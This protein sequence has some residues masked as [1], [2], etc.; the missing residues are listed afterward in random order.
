[1]KRSVL[2]AI[3]ILLVALSCLA[4]ISGEHPVSAPAYAPPPGYRYGAASASNG[5]DFLVVWR[6]SNRGSIYAPTRIYAA[7]ISASGQLLDPAGIRIP[8]R[9]TYP[10]QFN[11]VYL[12]NS[13]LVCWNEGDSSVATAPPPLLG[14]RV[15]TEGQLLDSTPRVF[16]DHGRLNAGGVAS[17][18]SRAVIAYTTASGSLT[19]IVLD[20]DANVVDGPR[21]LTNPAVPSAL[22]ALASSNGRGFLVLQ[23]IINTSYSAVISLDA[24]GTIT[25]N[26]QFL[27]PPGPLFDLASD[28]DGYLAIY[29]IPGQITAKHFGPGGDIL[30]T[31]TIPLQQTF[32]GL[33]FAG[34]SYLLVDA[35]SFQNVQKTIGIRRLSRTGQPVGGYTPIASVSGIYLK[36]TT[37]AFN[38]S[39]VFA[40]WVEAGT[41]NLIFNGSMIEAPTLA[42]S[43]PFTVARAATTQSSPDAASSGT[44]TAVVWNEDD[45]VYAARLT[46]DGQM[47]DGRGIRVSASSLTEAHIAFDGANYV[48]VW[49]DWADHYSLKV[50]RLAPGSGALLDPNGITIG[51][52]LGGYPSLA[53]GPDGTLLTCSQGRSIVATLLGRDLSHGPVVVV[54]PAETTG[55]AENS[56][57]WNG[58]EWLLTWAKLVMP[59]GG[60]QCDPVPC[61]QYQMNAA[62]LSPQLA[63]LDSAPIVI[64]DTIDDIG[65]PLVASDGDGFLV[66]WAR[67]NYAFYTVEGAYS[68]SVYTR[69]I[70]RDGALLP[71]ANV[72]L[73]AGQ[74]RSIAWDGLQY[75]VASTARREP[76]FFA[77][78]FGSFTA[79]LDVTHVAAHG[80]I[81]SLTP[82]V[83]LSDLS[84][85]EAAL[86]VTGTGRVAIAYTRTASEPEYG[87]VERVFVS[88]PH[89]IRGRAAR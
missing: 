75:D 52:N 2:A 48:I 13:Y 23:P 68:Y 81:E 9:T 6:D 64:S 33:V 24:N 77:R 58:S 73:A 89:V 44:N 63:L 79:T 39:S 55:S 1:M 74:V 53:A 35:D 87:E 46:L 66:A 37:L 10:S 5:H 86:I 30:D 12:G 17:N 42:A 69:R 43:T 3:P 51:Q 83:V 15:S 28:G 26:T 71:A 4:E 8:T 19:T 78:S 47:L 54:N 49:I 32:P 62:R 57:A 36:T 67:Y 11:V 65:R 76:A 38:G 61:Y 14:V 80:P 16:A 18:G 34:D 7:R 84:D 22:T 25:S 82:Q 88:I 45:G 59:D 40:G 85:P 56:A 70:S 29:G 20:R 41:R 60:P 31:S 72:R 27:N 50:A 21:T